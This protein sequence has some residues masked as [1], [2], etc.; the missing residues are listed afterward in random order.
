MTTTSARRRQIVSSLRDKEYR[1]ALVAEYINTGLPFQIRAMREDRGWTQKELGNRVGMAQETISLLEN[2]NYGRFT[3]TTLKRLASAFDV[4]LLIRFMP[5]SRL[6]DSVV[7]LS[8]EELAVPSFANDPGLE[9]RTVLPGIASTAAATPPF[10]SA[11]VRPSSIAEA[12]NST[13]LTGQGTQS[14]TGQGALDSVSTVR[15]MAR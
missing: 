2:P 8:A 11:R 13:Y 6:V 1:D 14:S 3:L 4:A 10:E 7:G 9:A 5:F 15:A 12:C